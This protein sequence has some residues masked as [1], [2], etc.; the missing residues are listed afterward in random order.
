MV[1][2]TSTGE[3]PTGDSPVPVSTGEAALVTSLYRQTSA[4]LRDALGEDRLRDLRAEGAGLDDN[5]AV[6]LALDAI[7]RPQAARRS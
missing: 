2:A 1:S 5:H 3:A 6:T 4:I 7:V